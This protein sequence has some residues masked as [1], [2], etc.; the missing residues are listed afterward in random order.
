[1]RKRLQE[2]GQWMWIPLL[3]IG[4]VLGIL[5]MATY[6]W[7]ADS[8]SVFAVALL[9]A[10]A[11]LLAGA[12][13]GFLF[14][15][16][17]SLAVEGDVVPAAKD[18]A[19]PGK[20]GVSY[21]SN[22]NLEQ[23]SDWLTKIIVGVGLVEL[24]TLVTET[25]NLVDFLTPALGDEPSS[26]AFA[27]AL[28]VFYSITG[29]LIT[30][31]VTRVYLGP[32]FARADELMRYVDERIDEVQESQRQR[33][34][35][36]VQALTLATRQ[37][38]AEA[39]EQ[40]KLDSAVKAASP[41]IRAQIFWRANQQRQ[42]GDPEQTARTIG[43]FR[44]LTAADTERRFHNNYAQLGYALK[45]QADPDFRAAEEALDTA[46]RIRDN[47]GERWAWS[48]LYELNR[49][50]SRIQTDPGKATG[51]ATDDD[52]RVRI[53]ADLRRAAKLPYLDPELSDD[54]TIKAWLDRNGLTSDDLSVE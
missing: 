29:F 14:G 26:P 6:A 50:L 31:L 17:R 33:G 38:E 53:L 46:I 3:A 45:D 44:A 9:V 12:L 24:R 11:S 7:S 49:A 42:R 15:I 36:D 54:E 1:M 5:A 32:V 39:V 48:P 25:Q 51:Q 16:P 23:I 35:R 40:D 28:L 52:L 10:G 19:E 22:T 21:R 13:L 30:Y 4:Q 43:V 41:L 8:A 20:R 34:E 2:I 18:A 37:L 47:L 27:L